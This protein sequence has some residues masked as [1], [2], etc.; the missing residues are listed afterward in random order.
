MVCLVEDVWWWM[1]GCS[2]MLVPG[3]SG[4]TDASDGWMIM[5][6]NIKMELQKLKVYICYAVDVDI[7]FMIL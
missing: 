2:R 4:K 3:Q 5:M 7:V 6:M 1:A